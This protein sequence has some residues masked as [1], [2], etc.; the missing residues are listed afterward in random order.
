VNN[1][2]LY[3][4]NNNNT[5]LARAIHEVIN[6]NDLFK[7]KKCIVLAF[8]YELRV[9][10]ELRKISTNYN[11][12]VKVISFTFDSHKGAIAHKSIFRKV[13]IDFYFGLGIRYLSTIDAVILFKSEAYKE[14]DLKIP[15]LISKA[16]VNEEDILPYIYERSGDTKFKLVY[17][18]TLIECNSIFVLI[19]TMRYLHD[20][21]GVTLDIYGRG[22]LLNYVKEASQKNKNINYLGL[23][24]N[25]EI[26]K[27]IEKADLLI[28]LRDLNDYVSKFAF[29]SKIIKYFASG[30]PVLTT[31]V[32]KDNDFD[33]AAFV[34]DELNPKK[35]SEKILEIIG[36]PSKQTEKSIYAKEYLK[37]KYLWPD[38]IEPVYQFCCRLFTPS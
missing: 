28:N 14:L 23:V 7:D 33:K 35:I 6:K 15:Y 31:R 3:P 24:N 1:L 32:I 9:L 29:P 18:G 30:V 11:Y 21:T 8:G 13:L 34:C 36:N 5:S 22:P 4:L 37:N 16:G 20:I 12:K 19:D 2:N 10:R 17:A 38:V 27:A 25:E 26:R